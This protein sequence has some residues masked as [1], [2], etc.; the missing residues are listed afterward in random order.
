MTEY[1]WDKFLTERDKAVFAAGG[2]GA[3][4]GFGKRPALVV[5]DVNWLF[6]GDKPEPILES[7]KRWR[8]SCGE[9]SWVAVEHIRQLCEA[10][11]AKG[12]PVIYTTNRYRAGD[13]WDAGSWRWKN[14][15]RDED[16]TRSGTNLDPS[17]IVAP[18]APGP[19]DIVI[20]KQKPSGFFG[21][22]MA[23]YL[24][25]LG[26]DSVILTGT[27]TSG[28]VRAT[29]VDAFSLNYRVAL[30]EEGCFDRSQASHALSLC[31]MHAKYADVVKTA[32]VLS[33]FAGLPDGLF[34][35]PAGT[36]MAPARMAAE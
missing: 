35:L 6:C 18:I 17:D 15:R 3:R 23:A 4:A 14:K 9:E 25:L 31:D 29:A 26:C 33:F 13:N 19:K 32:E 21:T 16:K 34:D 27:T 10:A 20:D 12:L 7:I 11:R 5:I 8:S 22:N 30:A 36:M 1:V 24:T 28:C 2:F